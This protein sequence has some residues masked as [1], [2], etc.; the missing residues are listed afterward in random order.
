MRIQV[1]DVRLFFDVE[2]SK[3]RPDGPTMRQ[4][5]T[6]LLLHGGPGFDHS[7][8]KPAFTRVADIT[9]VVYLDLR[10]N[11]RS[12]A[13]PRNKW[14][15]EQWAEDVHAFCQ[16]L[17]ID[18]P[19]VMGHSLGGIVAMIYAVRHPVHLSKLVLSSTSIQPVA[20]RSFAV[21]ERLGGPAAREAA[22]AFW[23]DPN[24]AALARYEELC[25]PL[26]TRRAPMAGY[27]ERAV[28][29]PDMRLVF[30]EAELQRLDLLRQLNRI[31][32]PTL[33]VAGEDDPITPLA[34]MEDIAAA[35]RPG[36]VRLARFA[37][38]GHGVY[39]DQPDGFFRELREFIAA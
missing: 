2:G 13:G 24:E 10:G 30:F 23:T 38:A 4:V 32:C 12:E 8:F 18:E 29:N 36:P 1:D 31:K 35:M 6:L 16:A 22:I 9:Q 11:G 7:G 19:I 5:P 37:N 28:R 14:T 15:L 39:R 17:S 3:L 25:I 20:E 33:I 26:Y 21:F 27:L 34:D